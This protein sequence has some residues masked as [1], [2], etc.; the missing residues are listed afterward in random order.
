VKKE[1]KIILLLTFGIA[2]AVVV[3]F[4]ANA[5]WWGLK[6]Q[7]QIQNVGSILATLALTA[8]FIER[9]VEVVITPWRDP[10][11]KER[12]AAVDKAKAGADEGALDSAKKLLNDYVAETTMYAFIAGFTFGLVGAMVGVRA[13]WPFLEASPGAITAF[14]GL[15]V[16]QR[17]TFII[18]DVVLSAALM[19][20][21]A[22]GIHSVVTA[23]TSFA[24]ANAQNS[25]N[26]VKPQPPAAA[27]Q[28]PGA[29]AQQQEAAAQG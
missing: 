2:T 26:S 9:A 1:A 17:N 22:D 12:Q 15:T 28:T 7:V 23:V 20:G 27:P 3:L 24:D 8:A 29:A 16:G 18:F 4:G 14:N 21:G 11:A 6:I 19:A 13:L 5:M 25:Q 10:E